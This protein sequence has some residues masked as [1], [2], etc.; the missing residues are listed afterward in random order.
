VYVPAG[1]VERTDIDIPLFDEKSGL[2]PLVAVWLKLKA[3]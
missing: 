2:E 1:R 3:N